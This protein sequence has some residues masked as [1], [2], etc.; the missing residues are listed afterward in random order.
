MTKRQREVLEVFKHLGRKGAAEYL[1]ISVKTVASTI[2]ELRKAG[3]IIPSSL[4]IS[5]KRRQARLR[6]K[7]VETPIVRRPSKLEPEIG[8]YSLG[9]KQDQAAIEQT[10]FELISRHGGIKGMVMG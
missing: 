8:A 9:A 6:R 5:Q 7:R 3:H 2:W 10:Y 1:G 4:S